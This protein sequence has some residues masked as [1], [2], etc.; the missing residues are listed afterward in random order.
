MKL[1]I[2]KALERRL[3]PVMKR[4]E[5]LL[6][7]WEWTWTTAFLAGIVISFAA[8]T[9]MAVIPSWF[10]YF[11]EQTLGWDQTN[12]LLLTLRDVLVTGYLTVVVGV[13]VV[14][15]YKLQVIRKRLRG[16]KQAERYS[17]GY[18]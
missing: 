16:E 17:G 14:T 3:R 5:E 15:L 12:R 13:F 4:G 18:R 10:L 1:P 2:P 6:R 7:D 9:S 8:I 11:A